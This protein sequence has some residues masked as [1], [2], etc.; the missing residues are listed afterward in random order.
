[1]T[2]CLFP[3]DYG[4]TGGFATS[5]DYD[6]L[7]PQILYPELGNLVLPPT[8]IP[9]SQPGI[10]Y[11][12]AVQFSATPIQV[13]IP[14]ANL[15]AAAW[16]EYLPSAQIYP[17]AG[18]IGNINLYD[19]PGFL[20]KLVGYIQLAG[21]YCEK[22]FYLDLTPAPVGNPTCVSGQGGCGAPITVLPPPQI[23]GQNAYKL[24]IPNCQC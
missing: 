4:A 19:G 6:F 12:P 23:P 10:G 15:L 18:I 16:Y 20:M 24:I 1:L 22:T 5:F 13:T 14:V 8:A 7:P 11:G 17:L 9:L 21:N 2:A 3:G